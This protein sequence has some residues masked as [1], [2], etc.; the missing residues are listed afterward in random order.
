MEAPMSVSQI[1]WPKTLKAE[2]LDNARLFADRRDLVRS[3]DRYRGSVVAEVGVAFGDFS[4]FLI[5]EL[6]P[7]KFDAYDYFQL[8]R[9]AS[10]WGKPPSETLRDATH[11]EFFEERF[12]SQIQ[13]G[14]VQIFEGDS[15]TYLNGQSGYLY[16]LIYLD[17]DHTYEGVRKDAAAAIG[18]L[19]PDGLLIFNDYIMYDYCVHAPYGVVQVV[20]ELCVEHGWKITHFALESSMFCDIAITRSRRH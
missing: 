6:A 8:H 15:S 9:S 13:T 14:I 18:K 10:M 20:N 7:T 11:R 1:I 5:D 19:K 2:H 12:S 3:L 4:Q 17:A 16:D